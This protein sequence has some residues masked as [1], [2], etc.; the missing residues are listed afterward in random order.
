[1]SAPVSVIVPFSPSNAPAAVALARELSGQAAQV[2]LAGD[3]P[4]EARQLGGARLV[5]GVPGKGR[6]IREAVGLAEGEIT[7]IQDPDGGY[8]ISS[9]PDLLAP[10]RSGTADAVYGVR[11]GPTGSVRALADQAVASLTRWVTQTG[12]S[13]PHTGLRAFR[14]GA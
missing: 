7:L 8:P 4:V 2:L 13:D 9:H 5:G 3:G 14:T 6:A 10:I 12:L 11:S 1:M